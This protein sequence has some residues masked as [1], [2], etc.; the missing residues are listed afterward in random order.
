MAIAHLL[1]RTLEVWRTVR[2]PDGAGG[3]T[4]TQV[5]SHDLDMRVSRASVSEKVLARTDVGPM[6][7]EA[8]LTHILYADDGADLLR[9]DDVHD[10]EN[11]ADWYRIMGVQRSTNPETYVR[12]EAKLDQ[13]EP[14]IDGGS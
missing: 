13:V 3:W 9:G 8:E 1:N 2:E 12:A 14:T 4:Q 11:P 7:G 5:F 10:P 6:Q